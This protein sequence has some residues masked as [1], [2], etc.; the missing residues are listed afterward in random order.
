MFEDW[1]LR[2][3]SI[4]QARLC[5]ASLVIN[6]TIGEPLQS[7][8]QLPLNPG[9]L[10][11]SLPVTPYIVPVPLDSCPKVDPSD[12]GKRRFN[13]C[14]NSLALSLEIHHPRIYQ[15]K[16]YFEFANGEVSFARVA[17]TY[18]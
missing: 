5:K 18:R 6:D 7:L 12:L 9:W 8:E 3:I 11:I 4:K 14:G 1:H 13:I 15:S 2:L 16:I 17:K 10:H